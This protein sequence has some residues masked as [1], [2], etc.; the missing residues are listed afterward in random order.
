M[1]NYECNN[2][3]WEG[4]ED[5]LSTVYQSNPHNLQDHTLYEGKS[6]PECGEEIYT[7]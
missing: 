2:C 6:C 1:D 4:N 3:M 7:H 5:E